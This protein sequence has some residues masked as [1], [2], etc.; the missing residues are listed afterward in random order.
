MLCSLR[1]GAYRG[2]RQMRCLPTKQSGRIFRVGMFLDFVRRS[3]TTRTM[4]PHGGV[5]QYV[6]GARRNRIDPHRGGIER[7]LAC[8][9]VGDDEEAV[10]HYA[11]A[12]YTLGV[13][14]RVAPEKN[15]SP[16]NKQTNNEHAN[17]QFDSGNSPARTTRRTPTRRT[18]RWAN[19]NRKLPACAFLFYRPST[20]LPMKQSGNVFRV[21]I[22]LDFVRLTTRTP[23]E[24]YVRGA[25]QNR[26]GPHRDEIERLATRTASW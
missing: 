8:T 11:G 24:A 16:F 2:R 22:F 12:D 9:C 10:E 19:G 18:C 3:G 26:I 1:R 6:R 15:R 20:D 25:K 21:S 14:V 5:P 13:H 4:H 23:H 7:L 17:G